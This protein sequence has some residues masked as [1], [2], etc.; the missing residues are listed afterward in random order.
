MTFGANWGT[1]FRVGRDGAREAYPAAGGT[2][3]E[4]GM[5]TPRAIRYERRG[6]IQMGVGGQSAV[7]IVHLGRDTG[8]DSVLV[9][10]Q[11]DRPDSPHFDDQARELFG[12]GLTK[13]SYFGDRK[14]LERRLT[15]KTELQF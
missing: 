9:P 1:V 4:A 14:E 5:E 11:S 13:P 8:S 15:G 2:V 6:A 10:G 7:Q 3:S 12:K